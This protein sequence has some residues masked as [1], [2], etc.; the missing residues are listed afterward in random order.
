M[1]APLTEKEKKAEAKI[2]D[3]EDA[4]F[5]GFVRLHIVDQDGLARVTKGTNA[6]GVLH[7]E[8]S[9]DG[10]KLV[11]KFPLNPLYFL[12][13]PNEQSL[14]FYGNLWYGDAKKTSTNEIGKVIPA[15][16]KDINTQIDKTKD[17]K[18]GTG[19]V[20]VFVPFFK[21]SLNRNL[22]MKLLTH[23]ERFCTKVVGVE[24]AFTKA[25]W[26]EWKQYRIRFFRQS[27]AWAGAAGEDEDKD[28]KK[29]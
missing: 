23:E 4:G 15:N 28:K 17:G 26:E 14:Y 21:D 5:C 1:A 2:F 22:K 29:E 18:K 16:C 9:G 6:E 24:V 13:I 19:E 8:K 11:A 25:E 3:A 20:N 27:Q 7:L 10:C 12:E